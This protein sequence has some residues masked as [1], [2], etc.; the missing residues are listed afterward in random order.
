MDGQQEQEP[1]YIRSVATE[2]RTVCYCYSA[3]LVGNCVPLFY[4]YRLED[5]R[6]NVDEDF[7]ILIKILISANRARVIMSFIPL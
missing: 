3:V 6:F 4:L 2:A 1:I 7:L 5:T